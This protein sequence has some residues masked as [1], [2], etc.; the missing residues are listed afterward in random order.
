[1]DTWTHPQVDGQMDNWTA[2]TPGLPDGHLDNQADNWTPGWM[3][4]G[5]DGQMDTWT[6]G[7]P[8]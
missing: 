1:M 2:R 5:M 8:E 3:D 6:G 4:T 7:P